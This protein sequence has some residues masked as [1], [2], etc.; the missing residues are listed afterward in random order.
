MA[1]K[2][3]NTFV[4]H[5]QVRSIFFEFA[6]HARPLLRPFAAAVFEHYPINLQFL[7]GPPAGAIMLL[8]SGNAVDL[9][10]NFGSPNG[11][12]LHPDH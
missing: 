5:I 6:Y 12:P 7:C 9:V 2:Q 3:T 1:N 4:T 8:Y 11:V 10:P